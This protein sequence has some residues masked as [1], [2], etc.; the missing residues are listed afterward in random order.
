MLD[1]LLFEL[2][3]QKEYVGEHTINTVY[4]GGGTPSLLTAQEIA[5]VIT[6]IEEKYNLSKDAE[7]TIEMNPDDVNENLVVELKNVG[8]N[9]ISLGIQSFNQTD[10]SIMNRAHNVAE[11]KAS[12]KIICST[13]SNVSIDLIY[14][15]HSLNDED[16]IN[17]LDYVLQYPINHLS[18]YALTVEEKTQLHYQIANKKIPVLDELKAANQLNVLMNWANKNEWKHYEISNLCKNEKF[19]KHNTAY[20]QGETYLGIGPA[21]HSFNGN[22]RQWNVANNSLYINS[23][24]QGFVPFTKELLSDLDI[25]NE[26]LMTGLRTIWGVK[27]DK[28]TALCPKKCWNELHSS[29]EKE[30]NSENLLCDTNTWKLTTKGKL[31]A[32]KIISNLFIVA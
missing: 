16:W 8:I 31:I 21:A 32:D 26:Y 20:W 2:E 28:L 27:L 10:L 19:A 29:L 25:T 17:N 6:T 7:I 9:R 4:F 22:S 5:S 23:I 18:C 11:A 24:K 14:G 13:F 3:L 30:V 1:C 12:L 15:S